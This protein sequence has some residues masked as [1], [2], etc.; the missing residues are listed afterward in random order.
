MKPSCIDTNV[1]GDFLA[2][3]ILGDR[4]TDIEVHFKSCAQCQ[5]RAERLSLR[6]D[7]LL[8]AARSAKVSEP[9]EQE[10]ELA[11]ALSAI[12][13]LRPPD[14]RG[15]NGNERTKAA[16]PE[17][18]NYRL[19]EKLGEGGMG[20]VY[21]AIHIRLEKTVAL[22]IMKSDRSGNPQAVSRFEREMK[23][24]GSL[25]HTHIV[26]ALD[27]GEQGGVYFLAMEYVAGT[28]LDQLIRRMGPL[29]VGDACEICRQ[30]ALGLAHA[31][32]HNLVHRDVKP[33]NLML[34]P[35]GLVKVL[36][37]GLAQFQQ[38]TGGGLELTLDG[39]MIGTLLYMSPEQLAGSKSIDHRS[40]I[41]SL[42]V[43]LYCLL[44]GGLPLDRGQP[45][46]MLPE[47]S[48]VRPDI[49][50]DVQSLLSKLLAPA[51][52]DRIHSMALVAELL[53]A[54]A[55]NRPLTTLAR[56]VQIR[57]GDPSAL[58][59]R[60]LP[61]PPPGE[62]DPATTPGS[63]DDQTLI[64]PVHEVEARRKPIFTWAN[65]AWGAA[66][67]ACLAVVALLFAIQWPKP[68][69]VPAKTGTLVIATSQADHPR[70]ADWMQKHN[71]RAEDEAGRS[72][73]LHPGPNSLP[74]GSFQLKT[75][76][77][78]NL[79]LPTRPIT[80]AAAQLQRFD[81]ELPAIQRLPPS[82]VSLFPTIPEKSGPLVSY[83]GTLRYKDAGEERNCSF[84]IKL[85]AKDEELLE[86]LPHRWIEIE[87]AT[88]AAD[89]EH[90]ETGLLL[91]NPTA[92]ANEFDFRVKRGWL[93]A[94]SESIKRRLA[95]RY[96]EIPAEKRERIVVGYDGTDRLTQRAKEL[97]APLPAGRL[98]VHH[99]LV[100]LFNAPVPY[101]PEPMKTWRVMPAN[102]R[103]RIETHEPSLR[104]R[105]HVL[106]SAADDQL[107]SADRAYLIDINDDVP[108]GFMQLKIQNENLHFSCSYLS[109]ND[110]PTAAPPAKD[111]FAAE[112]TS[113]ASLKTYEPDPIGEA[114]LPES[115]GAMAK[116]LG[117]LERN[118]QP[119]ID[120]EAHLRMAGT[121]NKDGTALRVL[122]IKAVTV[123]KSG[124]LHVEEARLR[125]NPRLY[126]LRKFRVED[127]WFRTLEETFPFE[128]KG[129]L[130]EV[131]DGLL[132]LGKRPPENRL[133]VHDILGL[134]F[135]A[136]LTASEE[137]GSLR[138][139]V[140]LKLIEAGLRE[141]FEEAQFPR[142]NRP[143]L[144]ADRWLVTRRESLPLSYEFIRS[145]QVA[146]DF[147]RVD[148]EIT[149]PQRFKIVTALDD[150]QERD[151]PSLFAE[152]RLESD[153]A[154]KSKIAGMNLDPNVKVWR[155]APGKPIAFAEFAG[156]LVNSATKSIDQV[157][158]LPRKGE[159]IRKRLSEL[160]ATD[161]EWVKQGRHWVNGKYRREFIHSYLQG[162]KRI[163]VCKDKE[164]ETEERL[165]FDD[166]PPA[167]QEWILRQV[168]YRQPSTR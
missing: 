122:E 150:D 3:R 94:E 168:S 83:T 117:T 158:L 124:A 65:S 116:Y 151:A 131:E 119:R 101:V 133:S 108:F 132:I 146:F 50:S 32:E 23:A 47:I 36:D 142:R 1:L 137:I 70:L 139:S 138:R 63:K 59:P 17:I 160:S 61:S 135:G 153:A 167:D 79:R 155:D 55:S 6:S 42:G 126:E 115:E 72:F 34:S 121:E 64:M 163:V 80:I 147:C 162:G 76:G 141:K 104:P 53:Q 97:N 18:A 111:V 84:S 96:P 67:L 54:S 37:L 129:D 120:F 105:R 45:A 102:D 123:P 127:G 113:I 9:V 128:P 144:T 134:M 12:G 16:A 4:A 7:S 143:S 21:R 166:F 159:L 90:K 20:T 69:P 136:Q 95:Y 125:I 106:Q 103:N 75:D 140:R 107:A 58:P 130:T 89:G 11:V 24:I 156:T 8:V 100:L 48:K 14:A 26:R 152:M 68:P 19:I 10:P 148:F 145:R 30:A 39:Q 81:V 49:P 44:A 154:T 25:E 165:L 149:Q 85:R 5:A 164:V 62:A 28:D 109:S 98:S 60:I 43:T 112:A 77:S 87:A 40:D 33:S 15:S 86:G 91:I 57:L 114:L 74:P 93:A 88:Y 56:Q 13:R 82:Q 78:E 110:T 35:D 92:Y 66:G 29:P 41:F 73:A 46:A 99:A 22:K 71:F 31:H 51:P 52:G 161:Q 27:A 118:G 2:G 157:L 38:S